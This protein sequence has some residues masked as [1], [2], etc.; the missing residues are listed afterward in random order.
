MWLRENE[1]KKTVN[2]DTFVK[3]LANHYGITVTR[4]RDGGPRK[5]VVNGA[6]LTKLVS[7]VNIPKEW[8]LISG[9]KNET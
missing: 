3:V 4:P 9:G 5:R 1:S 6:T 7:K 8:E 2:R